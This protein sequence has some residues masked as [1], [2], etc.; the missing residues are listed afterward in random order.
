MYTLASDPEKGIIPMML[1][2]KK[3]IKAPGVEELM[4]SPK[5]NFLTYWQPEIEGTPCKVIVM[6]MPSKKAVA[7]K[8]RIMPSNIWTVLHMCAPNTDRLST[9]T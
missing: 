1:L 6:D 2:D 3:S 8:V 9:E 4:W 7:Q 5:D